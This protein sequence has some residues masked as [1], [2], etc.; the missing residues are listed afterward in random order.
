MKTTGLKLSEVIAMYEQGNAT[1]FRP[2]NLEH[3]APY[4]WRSLDYWLQEYGARVL[5]KITWQ[6]KPKEVLVTREKLEAVICGVTFMCSD[7]FDRIAK[8]L[9]L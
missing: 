8:E 7:T 6:L 5:L 2:L 4:V 3:E 1:E 9:G